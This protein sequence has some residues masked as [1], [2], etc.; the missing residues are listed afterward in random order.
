MK[1]MKPSQLKLIEQV[2]ALG[3]K[4]PQFPEARTNPFSGVRHGLQPTACMLY[5]FITTKNLVCGK[6]YTRKL[7]DE[8]RMLFLE[9]WPDEYY[10]LLD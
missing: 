7:W 4:E 2:R 5:D 3:F 6:D 8:C 9:I 1:T 10:D